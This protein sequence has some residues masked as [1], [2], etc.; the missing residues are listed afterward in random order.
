M[1]SKAK[2]QDKETTETFN[3]WDLPK[4][5]FKAATKENLRTYLKRKPEH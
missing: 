4:N 2:K 5:F 1:W 3:T